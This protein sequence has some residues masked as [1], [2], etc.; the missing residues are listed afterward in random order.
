MTQQQNDTLDVLSLDDNSQ[1][2]GFE[3]INDLREASG[4]LPLTAEAFKEFCESPLKD[5][6][7][8]STPSKC[9]LGKNWQTLPQLKICFEQD[10]AAIV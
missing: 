6:P 9:T 5:N 2:V 3:L 10:L 4:M 8:T 7:K 1:V